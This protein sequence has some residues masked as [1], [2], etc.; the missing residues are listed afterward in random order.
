MLFLVVNSQQIILTTL[1]L[2]TSN[3]SARK[4]LGKAIENVNANDITLILSTVVITM[5][6]AITCLDLLLIY[7]LFFA[8]LALVINRL[9]RYSTLPPIRRND[10]QTSLSFL[11][12]TRILMHCLN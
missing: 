6:T 5:L 7:M 2:S 12:R 11:S 10:S 4:L 1:L 3:K 8:F 9:T